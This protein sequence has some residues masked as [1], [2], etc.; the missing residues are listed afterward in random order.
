MPLYYAGIG[1]R[2]T[3]K[4]ICQL[5]IRIAIRLNKRGYTLRSGGADGADAAFEIG[6]AGKAMI[7]LP[8][9]EFNGNQSQ[10]FDVGDDA[11]EIASKFHPKWGRCSVAARKLHGRNVYQVLGQDLKTPADF[12][13]CWTKDGGPTGGT[14]QAIRIAAAHGVPIFNLFNPD[15][16]ALLGNVVRGDD[17]NAR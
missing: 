16:L 3:P 4:R 8:W 10:L 12:V 14:G 2:K 9:K 6:A 17:S 1:S 11:L 5:M 15:A 13:V 7:F